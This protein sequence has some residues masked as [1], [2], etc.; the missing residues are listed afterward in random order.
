[1]EEKYTTAEHIIL[2][3]TIDSHACIN[4]IYYNTVFHSGYAYC[5]LKLQGKHNVDF[6]FDWIDFYTVFRPKQL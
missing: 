5:L 2:Q 4:N 6:R 1:M 3:L